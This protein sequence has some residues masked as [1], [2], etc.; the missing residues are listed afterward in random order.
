MSFYCCR[1]SFPQAGRAWQ[2]RAGGAATLKGCSGRQAVE[3]SGRHRRVLEISYIYTGPFF[4]EQAGPGDTEPKVQHLHRASSDTEQSSW[5]IA[6]EDLFTST[7][8]SLRK[9]VYSPGN[10][11]R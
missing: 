2:H 5:M 8:P 9:Y 3:L 11:W 6:M 4:L 7:F 1:A 10:F